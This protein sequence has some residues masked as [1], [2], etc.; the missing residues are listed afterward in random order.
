M[1]C[2]CAFVGHS[3]KQ[4]SKYQSLFKHSRIHSIY[5]TSQPRNDTR[6]HVLELRH[7][8]LRRTSTTDHEESEIKGNEFLK[9]YPTQGQLLY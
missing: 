9:H 5:A 3:K 7:L 4:K 2:N 8:V 1:N 6:L